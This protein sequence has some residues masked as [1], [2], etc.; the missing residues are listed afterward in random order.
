LVNA[1]RLI[2]HIDRSWD[3]RN[4]LRERIKA[5]LPAMKREALKT[6]KFAVRLLTK[7]IT[8]EETTAIKPES[9][10]EHS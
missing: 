6:N 9:A 8:R 1:G 4:P 10:A 5:A 2:A 7:P 3:R